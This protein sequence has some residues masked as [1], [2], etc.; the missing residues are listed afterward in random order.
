MLRKEKNIKIMKI[1]KIWQF[2]QNLQILTSSSYDVTKSRRFPSGFRK[3]QEQEEQEQQ[4][5]F[6]DCCMQ[7]KN[8]HFWLKKP[9]FLAQKPCIFGSKNMHFQLKK[10]IFSAS[11]LFKKT[12]FNRFQ[13]C[14]SHLHSNL[15]VLSF[16]G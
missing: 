4:S 12:Q 5:C 7:S 3:C 10:W 13:I 2:L 1:M 15:A 14:I 16:C 9:A 11:K 8:L 6:Q